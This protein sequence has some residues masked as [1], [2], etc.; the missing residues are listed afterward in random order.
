MVN[1][2]SIVALIDAIDLVIAVSNILFF[3]YYFL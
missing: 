2:S 3:I 1:Q